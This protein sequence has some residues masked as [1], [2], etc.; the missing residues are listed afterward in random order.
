MNTQSCYS[1]QSWFIWRCSNSEAQKLKIITYSSC[2][3]WYSQEKRLILCFKSIQHSYFVILVDFVL[4]VV[5]LTCVALFA[6]HFCMKKLIFCNVARMSWKVYLMRIFVCRIRIC[7]HVLNTDDTWADAVKARPLTFMISMMKQLDLVITS[8][9]VI[10]HVFQCVT[11]IV[12]THRWKW[13]MLIGESILM[14]PHGI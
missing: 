10:F 7:T 9:Y 2:F 12:C 8:K 4:V 14:L 11:S 13:Q 3:S 1:H 5:F 6:L